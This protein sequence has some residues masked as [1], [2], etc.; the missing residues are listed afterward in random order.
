VPGRLTQRV[1]G[2]GLGLFIVQSAARRHGGTVEAESAGPDTG[3]TFRM[4]LPL[5]PHPEID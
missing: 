2:T 4:R 5:A 3:A 1:K